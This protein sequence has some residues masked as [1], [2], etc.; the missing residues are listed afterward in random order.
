MDSAT[1]GRSSPGP[2]VDG[3][4]SA[5]NARPGCGILP[6]MTHATTDDDSPV[7]T[8]L[9]PALLVALVAFAAAW[10]ALLPGLAFWDT[11]EL[12]AVAPLMGTAHPDRVPDLRPA[13]LAG[14][15]RPP[16][17]RRAGLPDEPVLGAVRGRRG[18]RDGGP[19]PE[20]DRLDDPRDRRRHRPGA[21]PDRLGDRDPCRGPFAPPGAPRD[22]AL[23]PR[24]LGRAR[25]CERARRP[26]RSR[27]PVPGGRDD[28]LRAGRRQP[29]ADVAPGAPGR[30]VRA[31]GRS[32]D[33]A[34][35][36][37]GP[38]LRRGARAHG[39]AGLPR[40]AAA[41]RAVPRR[42]RL[43]HP[44]HPR[45]GS[46]TSSWPSSSRAACPTRSGSCRASSASWSPGRSPSSA[47]SRRSSRSRSS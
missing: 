2:L 47:S 36:P 46:A 32:R 15:G 26:P 19:R 3:D 34:A 33:L 31:G 4:S 35:R 25:R 18:R 6:A 9:L 7:R 24:H 40:A 14:L 16:A 12:Q 44:E 13:R 1:N 43:R 11:G 10:I 22:P 29:L 21:D 17:V 27:R 38:R 5:T 41:R 23:A 37:A 30:A 45:T 28:R 39:H 42:P 8:R 20:A